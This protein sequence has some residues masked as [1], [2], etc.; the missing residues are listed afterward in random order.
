MAEP[1]GD[2]EYITVRPKRV[3]SH[4]T[5]NYRSLHRGTHALNATKSRSSRLS[6]RRR[7]QREVVYLY[8]M[9]QSRAD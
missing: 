4:G 3:A 9:G 7:M 1:P 8:E 2:E 5:I 6:E